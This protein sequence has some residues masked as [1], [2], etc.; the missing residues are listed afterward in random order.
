VVSAVFSRQGAM[1]GGNGAGGAVQVTL[2][3]GMPGIPMPKPDVVTANRVVDL[4]RGLYKAEPPPKIPVEPKATPIPEFLKEKPPVYHTPRKSKLLE[5]PV[6]PPPNAIPY[7]AGG[8]AAVPYSFSVS[9]NT[10]GALS[11]GGPAGPAGGFGARYP[12]YVEA[13][14]RRVSSNWLESTVD[15]TVRWAPRAVIDFEILRDGSIVNVYLKQSSG[16]P[17][18]DASAIRAIHMSSPLNALPPEYQGSYVS[19]EFYFDFKR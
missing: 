5:N 1:W 6:Q 9:G 10:Q 14:Q 4:S 18:V 11:M 7:G 3:G 19:V 13:V 17:S 12:W 16:Y 15:P 2:V 8:P